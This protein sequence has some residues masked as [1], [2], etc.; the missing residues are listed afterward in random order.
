MGLD[1]P[2]EYGGQGMPMSG[3]R[4]WARCCHPPTWRSTCIASRM[5][6]SAIVAHGTEQDLPAPDDRPVGRHHELEPHCGTDLGLMR[7][8]A[9]PQEDGTYKISGQ[10]IWICR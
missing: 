4:L 6:M 7:T 2:E 8:K 10:K 5:A 9:E 3:K 1:M